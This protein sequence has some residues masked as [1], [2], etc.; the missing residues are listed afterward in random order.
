MFQ[1]FGL[2]SPDRYKIDNAIKNERDL[3]G[4]A[5]AEYE[6]VSGEKID[7]FFMEKGGNPVRAM[8]ATTWRSGSTFLGIYQYWSCYSTSFYLKEI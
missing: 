7:N 4:K 3:L 2:R 5:L 8:V 1:G 6:T